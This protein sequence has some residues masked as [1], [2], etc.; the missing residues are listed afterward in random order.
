V[1]VGAGVAACHVVWLSPEFLRD[2]RF[3]HDA[4]IDVA[5][6]APTT[7]RL[8]FAN[9]QA[10]NEDPAAFL[11]EVKDVEPDI[12]LFVECFPWWQAPV[13]GHPV[14]AAYPYGTPQRNLVGGEHAIY[15][16]LPLENV[17]RVYTTN[18]T[19]YT[20]DVRVDGI[21]L[22]VFCLHAPR[23][24]DL[25]LH[26]SEHWDYR[27]YWE[28]LTPQLLS[29]PDPAVIVGDF[30]ATPH[31]RVYKTLTADRLRSAH[32]D[33]G[34]GYATTWPNGMYLIPPIRIDQ[35]LLSSSVECVTIREGRG[36]GSDHKPLILDIR[37]RGKSQPAP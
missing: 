22:R 23:P 1:L 15:S 20:F 24:T 11:N 32:D 10:D 25:P 3:D 31:S 21:P 14:L 33:R 13:A 6:D 7:L 18:R 8:F 16:K 37:I 12:L 28:K 19:S 9:V 29:L 4:A 2:R 17:R 26:E 34:R 35:A 36:L 30:N 27:G 5:A